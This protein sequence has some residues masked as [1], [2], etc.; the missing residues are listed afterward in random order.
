MRFF[1][2]LGASLIREEGDPV[3]DSKPIMFG[4]HGLEWSL[5]ATFWKGRSIPKRFNCLRAFEGWTC[6]K[7]EE[8][9]QEGITTTADYKVVYFAAG[10]EYAVWSDSGIRSESEAGVRLAMPQTHI[11]CEVQYNPKIPE[12]SV[13][14]CR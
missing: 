9:P 5:L 1:L 13:A 10:H 12:A 8:E 11:S 4:R 14:S 7:S 3:I 2:T 6:T